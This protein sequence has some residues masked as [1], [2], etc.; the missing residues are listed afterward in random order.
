M[1]GFGLSILCVMSASP[2]KVTETDNDAKKSNLEVLDGVKSP[3]QT[4]FSLTFQF[5][6]LSLCYIS[7]GVQLVFPI[8]S[9][10]LSVAVAIS[11]ISYGAYILANF[12]IFRSDVCG[13]KIGNNQRYIISN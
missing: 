10:L 12:C 4:L 2:Y 1:I 8:Y 11:L 7:T 3:K 6:L 13:L 5:I 9:A